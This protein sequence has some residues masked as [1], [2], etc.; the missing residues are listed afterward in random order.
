MDS[1]LQLINLPWKDQQSF[2]KEVVRKST[3]NVKSSSQRRIGHADDAAFIFHT[4]GTSTGLPKP[5]VQSHR[6]AFGVLPVLDGHDSATFTTTPLYHGGIADCLRAWTSGAAIWLYPS[7]D[8]PITS[9]NI[10]SCLNSAKTASLEK[11]TAPVRY[12]SSVPYIL[13]MLQEEPVGLE[14][15]QSMDLVGVGG[16]ALDTK[17]GDYLVDNGVRLVSRYGSA[18]CGFLLSSHRN[19]GEDKSWSYLRLSPRA[20][21]LSFEEQDDGSGLSEMVV[22]AGWPHMAKVNRPDGSFA[23]SDLFEPHPT[24]NGAWKHHSR[25]DSQ[26]TLSTGK[27][28]DPEPLENLITSR[29]PLIREVVIFGSGR[30]S[31]GI[32]VFPSDRSVTSS[33]PNIDKEVWGVLE[34]V[35]SE[36]QDHTRIS[37]NMVVLMTTNMPSLAR[38]SKGT[39]AR[40]AAEKLYASYID[41]A[42]SQ[43]VGSGFLVE[44]QEE[45]PDLKRLI[46]ATITEALGN[47]QKLGD[48]DDFYAHGVDSAL[49]TQIRSLLQQ[50]ISN[51]SAISI[52]CSYCLLAHPTMSK[53]AAMECHIRRWKCKR[54]R[55]FSYSF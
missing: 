49:C 2:V 13:Q 38:S 22:K 53:T 29:S 54:V 41:K 3:E 5:I 16:A 39:L 24:I 1:K 7:A 48:D 44:H 28:F 18:E 33:R 9:K 50:V 26:I 36:G 47:N 4:S 23:T 34:G 46:S 55:A 42:Y 35:N 52:S 8:I 12:F 20:T 15:L 10:L 45:V 37:R 40:A 17:T 30:Q 31:A 19:Y 11:S 32:L 6:V 43:K 25:S 51:V 27:K 21:K 14:S